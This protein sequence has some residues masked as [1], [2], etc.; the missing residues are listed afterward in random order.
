MRKIFLVVMVIVLAI[1]GLSIGYGTYLNQAGESNIKVRL[2]DRRLELHGARAAERDIRARLA[3]DTVNMYSNEMTDAIALVDGRISQVNV[4]KNDHVAKGTV[5]YTLTNEQQPVKIRQ[6]EIEIVKA[7]RDIARAE[8]DIAKAEAGLAK[9]ENDYGRYGRL[10]ERDAVTPQKFDEVEAIYREAQVNVDVAHVGYEQ[11]QAQRDY[12]LAQKEQLL[13]DL[14]NTR[15]TAPIDGDIILIYKQL[16][17]Y[18]TAGTPLALVGDFRKLYFTLPLD[19]KAARGLTIGSEVSL[20]FH[21]GDFAK[22]YDTVYARGNAGSSQEFTARVV[23]VSPD[24]EETAAMRTIIF[25]VDNGAGLL[26]PQTYNNVDLQSSVPKKALAVPL[27]AL[28]SSRTEVFVL[29]S[30][31]VLQRRQVSTGIDD[32]MYVEITSGLVPG[33]VVVTSDAEGL[34][35]GMKANVVLDEGGQ[36]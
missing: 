7:E 24:L 32:G 15:V 10:R 1:V 16:G 31:G 36:S 4:A 23:S 27:S 28:D 13:I 29:D 33:D 8:G 11:A 3:V 30:D 19:D 12:L 26:E 9:A 18:V 5:L 6:A 2:A 25:E 34:E 22:I 14:A 17:A 20:E 21:Q 35:S